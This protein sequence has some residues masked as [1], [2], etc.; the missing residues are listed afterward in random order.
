ML[1]VSKAQEIL[2][3]H[4]DPLG[5]ESIPVERALNRVLCHPIY[6]VF[7]MPPFNNSSMDGFAVRSTDTYRAR[8]NHPIHLNVVGDIP[9][10]HKPDV[11]INR[12]EAARIVTGAMVPDGADAII[13]VE[14][15]G[16]EIMEPGS[17]PPDKITISSQV[18][19]GENVRN[20]GD[21]IGKG[22]LLIKSNRRLRPQDIG[23]ITM[24][25][26]AN[27]NVYRQPKV[28]LLSTG[29]ELLNPGESWKPGKVYDSNSYTLEALCCQNGSH[30]ISFG[31]SPDTE[32]SIRS[33]LQMAVQESVDLIITTAGVSLGAFDYVRNVLEKEGELRFWRVNMRPGKPMLFGN[34]GGI[35]LIGLPGNPV[36][37]FIGF[38]VFVIPVLY[39]LSGRGIPIRHSLI[40]RLLEPIE[41]D[42]RE[43]YLRAIVSRK[44]NDYCVKLTGHQGSG[45]LMSL[46]HANALIKIP[47][48]VIHMPAGSEV[49][50]WLFE[51]NLG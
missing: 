51:D 35:P 45:N 28:G 27:L 30:C 17:L 13:P 25:G 31:P 21:D 41:S 16:L 15:T 23:V 43:S 10:G 8:K 26:I 47:A 42:G 1:S 48:G 20:S 14:N 32:D 38:V 22:E 19:E 40:A 7:D 2:L 33:H 36:S 34:Y 49:E 18:G 24:Q 44:K 37:A 11:I 46:V 4:F 12:G 6:A 39:K 9:A 50:V 29:D 3:A 5:A